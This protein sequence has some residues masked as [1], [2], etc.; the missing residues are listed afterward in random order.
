MDSLPFNSAFLVCHQEHRD[1]ELKR[2]AAENSDSHRVGS[3]YD[4]HE[5]NVDYQ[6][7]LSFN[8]KK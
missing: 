5:K 7:E 4:N 2:G 8:N 3:S 6:F 1:T